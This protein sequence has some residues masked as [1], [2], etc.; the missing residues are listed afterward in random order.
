MATECLSCSRSLGLSGEWESFQIES[1]DYSTFIL[2]SP[3]SPVALRNLSFIATSGTEGSPSFVHEASVLSVGSSHVLLAGVTLPPAPELVLLLWDL[4][5]SVLLASR[6]IPIPATVYRSKKQG[7]RLQLSGSSSQQAILILSP[8]PTSATVRGGSSSH[9]TADDFSQR[10]NIFVV[11]L[12]VPSS[13]TVLNALGR[14]SA[15]EKWLLSAATLASQTN[16]S[17]YGLDA[18]QTKLIRQMRAG[19]EQKRVEAT[20]DAFFAWVSQQESGRQGANNRSNSKLQFGYQLVKQILELV[21]RTPKNATANIP[22]SPKVVRYLLQQ[23]CVSASMVD[24]GLFAALRLR[25]DWVRII[26]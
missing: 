21:F 15:G 24:G 10:S 12:V 7:I 19:M 5:Y 18:V 3:S 6:V 16:A 23:R 2:S 4:Q 1:P 8:T 14:A 9:A 25:N 22:Y 20:D 11:P 17:D 13:S 26:L